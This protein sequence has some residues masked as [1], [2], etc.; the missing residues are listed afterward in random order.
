MTHG[1]RPIVEYLPISQIIAGL[2]LALTFG[3]MTF[4]SVVMAPLV[5]TKLPPKIAGGFIRQVFPWYYLAMG[6]ASL[7][8]LI[9][10]LVNTGLRGNW[11]TL[12]TA[13]VLAGFVF[14]RQM[15]LPLI[16]RARDAELA[17]ETGAH[18]R[19]TRLHGISVL[20]NAVQWLAVLT[21]LTLVLM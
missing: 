4:F 14:A 20:I 16:N 9:G 15:L 1:D 12:L 3:G 6:T 2:S 21:A 7:V 18:H 11:E 10:L 17:G 5:F 13:L 8:A 19:F